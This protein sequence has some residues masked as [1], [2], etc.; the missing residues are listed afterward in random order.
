MSR[1]LKLALILGFSFVLAVTVLVSD[2]WRTGRGSDLATLPGD[3]PSQMTTVGR[4]EGKKD[5]LTPAVPLPET[6]PKPVMPVKPD[7]GMAVKPDSHSSEDAN[8]LKTSPLPAGPAPTATPDREYTIA[9][10]DTLYKIAKQT[11]SDA[12]LHKALA[13]YNKL[14]DGRGLKVGAK[15][16]L[17]DRA[18][19]TGDALPY[20]GPNKTAG[21]APKPETSDIRKVME[22]TVTYKIQP[23]DTLS[24]I[25]RKA[26][27]PVS[28][29][30]ELNKSLRGREDSLTVGVELS[31]PKKGQ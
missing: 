10:G 9:D 30:L 14:G 4:L 16:K 5:V 18:V 12:G 26:G 21:T 7:T 3:D 25:A 15:I 2:H 27:C 20:A 19:L 24:S 31:V 6:D 11:Y 23:G 1:E 8:G 22:T 29:L 13:D 17:P 28:K